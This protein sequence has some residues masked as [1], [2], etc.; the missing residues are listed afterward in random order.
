MRPHQRRAEGLAFDLD[1]L[2][3]EPP[4]LSYLIECAL[5]CNIL[6][7][8]HSASSNSP[9]VWTGSYP[10]SG[11]CS[12]NVNLA[13]STR[14]TY[15]TFHQLLASPPS[16]PSFKSRAK[17]TSNATG[18]LEMT[19]PG[20]YLR[21][22]IVDHI[23]GRSKQT[24]IQDMPTIEANR[25]GFWQ[26]ERTPWISACDNMFWC[27][28]EIAR[29]LAVE[30]D[31]P[32]WVDKVEFA[33]IRHPATHL[34]RT[35]LNS[36]FDTDAQ[37]GGED[38]PL[39]LTDGREP[40]TSIS[41]S[42]STPKKTATARAE[43]HLADSVKLTSTE[44]PPSLP[45]EIWLR[46]TNHL[47]PPQGHPGEISVS[48][49]KQYE[50]AKKAAIDSGEVLFFGRIWGENVL[51]NLEWTRQ[52]PP[53][54]LPP[55]LYATS[56]EQ[57]FHKRKQDHN[58]SYQYHEES[59]ADRA[60]SGKDKNEHEDEEPGKGEDDLHGLATTSAR[61]TNWLEDLAWSPREDEYLTAYSKVV[62][63]RKE[64][65]TFRGEM[66]WCGIAFM[67]GASLD[68]FARGSLTGAW[69]PHAEARYNRTSSF[70]ASPLADGP[71]GQLRSLTHVS[72]SSSKD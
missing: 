52:K 72:R 25:D 43:K 35:S 40:P 13:S 14:G 41:T 45:R 47:S 27:I 33:V 24:C 21:H 46:P 22:T 66:E 6:F 29:R 23:Q 69:R 65:A 1:R 59:E 26:D 37:A 31:S 36:A 64:I 20:P 5:S 53:F 55:Q 12:P 19:T 57:R 11:F 70:G 7:R 58:Y 61:G 39:T 48:L 28:W 56:S 49:K 15:T 63:R 38:V 4:S 44:S 9:L 3:S 2:Q 60:S 34:S 32:A 62:Q 18:G 16:F 68:I 54:P 42:T 67:F 50:A 8:V 10:T 30:D 51:L 17:S 71:G